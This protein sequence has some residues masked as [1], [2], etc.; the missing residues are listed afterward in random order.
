M[1][2][3]FGVIWIEILKALKQTQH[4]NLNS[5]LRYYLCICKTATKYSL[6][7]ISAFPYKSFNIS[8]YKH[9]LTI[10]STTTIHTVGDMIHSNTTNEWM[11]KKQKTKKHFLAV[12]KK[13]KKW[14]KDTQPH[15]CC[16]HCER[17]GSRAPPWCCERCWG[18][19]RGGGAAP[20]L[21]AASGWSG[22]SAGRQP[23][24]QAACCGVAQGTAESGLEGGSL[25]HSLQTRKN[26]TCNEPETDWNHL[27]MLEKLLPNPFIY[28][29]CYLDLY[30][31]EFLL[32]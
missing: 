30:F 5:S 27:N 19:T 9:G 1:I 22:R 6:L 26:E 16:R 31:K 12:Y 11:G 17:C 8:T 7:Y 24:S 18:W 28:L 29:S 23:L 21:Q 4:N 13:E 32:N 25:T 3:H 2:L 14:R 20:G 15:F 10:V